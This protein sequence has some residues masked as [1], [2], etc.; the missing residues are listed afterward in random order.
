MN[1]LA[2]IMRKLVLSLVRLYQICISPVLPPRCI[3]V[4]TCSEYM[5]EAVQQYGAWYGLWLGV[6]RLFRCHPFAHG[7]YDPVPTKANEK[8]HLLCNCKKH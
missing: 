1:W 8:A 3:H 5:L 4:P 6:K 2:N 7:G